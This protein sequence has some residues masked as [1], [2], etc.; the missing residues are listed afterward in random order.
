M[1]WWC[2]PHSHQTPAC[3]SPI[4]PCLSAVLYS[5]ACTW[6]NTS[7]HQRFMVLSWLHWTITCILVHF[8]Q[9]SMKTVIILRTV[10]KFAKYFWYL[11]EPC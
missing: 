10:M 3:W 9:L 5:S 2:S 1:M 7:I 8:A 4:P 6:N 11:F